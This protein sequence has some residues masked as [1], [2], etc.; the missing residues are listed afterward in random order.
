MWTDWLIAVAVNRVRRGQKVEDWWFQMAGQNSGVTC[1][2]GFCR[3][4][5]V[6]RLGEIAGL[7]VAVCRSW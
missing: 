7:V 6:W 1:G 5:R 3:K 4:Q 2:R